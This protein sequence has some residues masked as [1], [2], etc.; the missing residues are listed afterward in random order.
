MTSFD[1]VFALRGL[2]SS[3]S[4]PPGPECPTDELLAAYADVLLPIRAR[5]SLE[6]HALHCAPCHELVRAL[7]DAGIVRSEPVR[8][9]LRAT[10]STPTVVTIIGRL[11]QRGIELLNQ[12]D[13]SF[14]ARGAPVPVPVLGGLRSTTAAADLVSIRGPGH[15]IDDIELQV[16]PNGTARLGV[17][18]D[19]LPDLPADEVLSIVLAVDGAPREKRPF[20]GSPVSFAPIGLGRY[21][22]R[23]VARAPGRQA[24][25]LS[26]AV[27]D[28]SA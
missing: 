24:R 27:I 10:S 22:I 17:R 19:A 1:H 4:A 6:N 26:R 3:R 2:L 12:A 18:C 11:V 25:E 14:G 28:L 23:L 9:G 21:E 8:V 20:D 16:Q 7:V 5:E 15:G 13:L